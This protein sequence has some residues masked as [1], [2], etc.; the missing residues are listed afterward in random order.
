VIAWPDFIFPPINLLNF[1]L[2]NIDFMRNIA[3]DNRARS[4]Q[5]NPR[6]R[7][8]SKFNTHAIM[9][10]RSES[11]IMEFERVQQVKKHLRMK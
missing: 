1:P 6:P 4:L 9:P 5:L 7:Q 11:A 3:L 10:P 8:T 2:Q